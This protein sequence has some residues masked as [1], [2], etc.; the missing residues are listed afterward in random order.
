VSKN[1]TSANAQPILATSVQ[2]NPSSGYW[3]VAGNSV[4]SEAPYPIFCVN[5]SGKFDTGLCGEPS[6]S[7]DETVVAA[8]ANGW[9]LGRQILVC[10]E[11][12]EL[13]AVPNKEVK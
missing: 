8:Y 7:R 6:Q 4:K 10:P 13:M 9:Y 2:Y 3:T 1:T 5:C 12:R 11:C